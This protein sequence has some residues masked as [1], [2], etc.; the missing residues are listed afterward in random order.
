MA[1]MVPHPY[2]SLLRYGLTWRRYPHRGSLPM[3][4]TMAVAANAEGLDIPS[5]NAT[6]PYRWLRDACTCPSCIHPSTQQKLHRTSDTP[7]SIAPESIETVN[8]GVHISW[9]TADRHRS[10]F[11]KAFLTAHASP[12]ALHSFHNDVP[13]ALWPTAS[14]LFSA[15]GGD[16]EIPYGDLAKSRGLLR[17]ITQL[18]RTGLLILRGV[19]CD[20]TSD[21]GCEIRKVAAHFAEVRGSFY[22]EVWNV[23]N[24]VESRN[25]AYT[26]LFLGLHMDLQYVHAPVSATPS[27]IY[28]SLRTATQRYLNGA[29]LTQVF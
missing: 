27:S 29:L 22:G 8:D 18:Q 5:L 13:A 10:F 9:A 26:N 3:I 14:A 20:D 24:V 21:E 25:I 17:A 11:P 7:A 4:S 16:L 23:K 12:T 15:S 2:R 1:L 19:P 6:F 28:S